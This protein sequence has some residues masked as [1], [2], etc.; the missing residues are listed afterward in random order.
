[1]PNF[2]YEAVNGQGRKVKGIVRSASKQ[3]A[4]RQLRGQ[5]LLVQRVEEKEERFWEKDIAVG[6][7]VRLKEFALFCRQFAVLLN[8]G[9][10]IDK[11]LEIM[12][13]QTANKALRTSLGDLLEQ[14]NGGMQLS[15]AM[16]RH[17]RIYPDMFINMLMS[18][19]TGGRLDETL[20][21][22]AEH[23]EKEHKTVQKVKSAMVY[24]IIVLLFSVAVVIFLLSSI[25]PTF[26]GMFEDQGEA[27][28]A[29]T[30]LVMQASGIVVD[31]GWLLAIGTL[32]AIVLSRF[33]VSHDGSKEVLDR[34]KFHI[35]LFG[36]VLRKAAIARM[37]RTMASLYSSGV[38]LLESLGVTIRVTGNRVYGGV[39]E[40]AQQSLTEGRQLSEPF[41]KS[42][43]FPKM[44]TSMLIVGEE[45]GQID[46]MFSKIADFYENDVEQS[47]DRLKVMVE[48]LLLLLV[49][50]VVGLIIS[51]VMSPMFQM[52][53]NMLG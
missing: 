19:E 4:I 21:R 5:Q 41:M 31:Y 36:P 37:T 52:Y 13:E 47:V 38:P 50:G 53:D 39:L 11:A 25:V 33:A 23:Y 32:I 42:G 8:A 24:P 27:L 26:V 34:L 46:R 29:V 12:E 40:A 28:P 2:A 44:V 15:R 6:K 45:T 18:G 30:R 7:R 43:A 51:A 20:E 49:S 14:V 35:P 1:M 17:P 10:Q 22:M 9:V 16:Q 3:A 48:P